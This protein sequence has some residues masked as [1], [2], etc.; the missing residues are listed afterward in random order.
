MNKKVI[1]KVFVL[2]IIISIGN[3]K[4]LTNPYNE[5]GPYGVNCTWYTWKM[6]I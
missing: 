3:V 5:K 4:A 1:L 6:T 2:I